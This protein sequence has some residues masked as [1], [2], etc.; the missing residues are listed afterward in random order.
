MNTAEQSP[1]AWRFRI[2]VSLFVLGLLS[3]LGIPLVTATNLSTTWKTTLSGLLMLGIPELFWLVAAAIMGKPGFN[4]LKAKVFGTFK[5]YT[6]PKKVSRTRYRLGLV[7][8]VI[9]LLY[10]W[11]EPYVSLL[12]SGDDK[13]Q[14]IFAIAGDVLLLASLFVLGSEFWEKLG[15]LFIYEAKPQI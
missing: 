8:L 15:A 3:P 13:R 5:R 11:L 12:I 14:V 9:P 1:P 10:G 6:L 4:Y 2:G 7:M